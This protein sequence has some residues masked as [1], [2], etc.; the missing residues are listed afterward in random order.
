MAVSKADLKTLTLKGTRHVA[1]T[2]Q[3]DVLDVF[4]WAVCYVDVHLNGL[5]MVIHLK[6]DKQGAVTPTIKQCSALFSLRTHTSLSRVAWTC[7]GLSDITKSRVVSTEGACPSE[8]GAYWTFL[9]INFT[10]LLSQTV[11]VSKLKS[12]EDNLQVTQREPNLN[13]THRL[14]ILP[15]WLSA[16]NAQISNS[17]AHCC[18]GRVE[19]DKWA[20]GSNLHSLSKSS[21][22]CLTLP[23]SCGAGWRATE[24]GRLLGNWKGN[25]Y[26]INTLYTQAA[27]REIWGVTP[28][29]PFIW[30]HLYL[31][32]EWVGVVSELPQQFGLDPG[33]DA[34]V[35][36]LQR[37][38]HLAGGKVELPA[39]S[40]AHHV[41]VIS[42]IAEDAGQR[43]KH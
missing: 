3:N 14:R 22:H 7:R 30:N 9:S 21:H 35:T 34:P 26:I 40:D 33:V 1:I 16:L 12:G 23:T 4:A 27:T 18:K 24:Q 15:S 38:V 2:W 43:D 32:E 37:W 19:E 13:S 10:E 42:A 6:S 8:S 28:C 31:K 5:T 39:E 11:E 29:K 25:L 20:L 41:H 36:V 17:T